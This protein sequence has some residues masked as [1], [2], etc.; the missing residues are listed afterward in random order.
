MNSTHLLGTRR[1]FICRTTKRLRSYREY[2]FF[3]WIQFRRGMYMNVPP[4]LTVCTGTFTA[5]KLSGCG[6]NHPPPFN[7]KVKGRIQLYLNSPSVT[8]RPVLGKLHLCFYHRAF[9]YHSLDMKHFFTSTIFLCFA[10]R[11]FQYIYLS[12]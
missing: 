6:V 10:D 3:Q 2:G 9:P 8:S 11:A 1:F 7:T 4:S 5:I 12:I